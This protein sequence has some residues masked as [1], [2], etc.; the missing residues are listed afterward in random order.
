MRADDHARLPDLRRII[1]ALQSQHA[2]H[3]HVRLE[4]V[5]LLASQLTQA[6][7]DGAVSIAVVR[8]VVQLL[9][10]VTEDLAS[11]GGTADVP[12]RVEEQRALLRA[13]R[14]YLE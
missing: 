12:A 9:G 4:D 2:D 1:S 7:Q 6:S 5:E 11:V 14:A 8:Q 13:L 10:H 3:G